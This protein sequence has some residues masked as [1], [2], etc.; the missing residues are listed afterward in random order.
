MG[1]RI[2]IGERSSFNMNR[3]RKLFDVLEPQGF[4]KGLHYR[5]GKLIEV[6]DWFPNIITNEGKNDLWDVYF[7]DGTQKASSSWFMGLISDASYSAIAAAN[8]MASHAG[9]TEFT[10][11]DQATRPAWGPGA[12]SSQI[13]TNAS[14][15]IFDFNDTGT[16]KGIF[17][18]SNSTKGGTTGILFSAG[19]FTSGD[20]PVVDEDQIKLTY[21]ASL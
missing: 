12:P 4:Y 5:K 19:L 1:D 17:I 11:Y 10:D 14:P 15:A 3:K 21:A 6:Y 2:K 16:V 8:T 18:T 20:V 7:S 9:W 13:I